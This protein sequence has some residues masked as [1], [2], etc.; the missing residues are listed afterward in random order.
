MGLYI[1]GVIGKPLEK[2]FKKGLTQLVFYKIINK[3]RI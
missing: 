2:F 3:D 1:L